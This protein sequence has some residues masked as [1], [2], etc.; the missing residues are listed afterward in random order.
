LNESL[1]WNAHRAAS[2]QSTTYPVPEVEARCRRKPQLCAGCA[3]GRWLPPGPHTRHGDPSRL[4][5][6]ALPRAS[7]SPI[8]RFPDAPLPLDAAP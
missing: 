5:S 6:S 4:P 7:V 3:V 8:R 1:R 2:K